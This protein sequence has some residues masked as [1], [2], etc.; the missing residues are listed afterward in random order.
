MN[1]NI[2]IQNVWLVGG[3]TLVKDFITLRLADEIIL[4]I[5]S[6]TYYLGRQGTIFE[7]DWTRTSI[8][9]KRRERI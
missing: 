8:T 4:S 7:P 6:I 9:S 5:L 3:A 2:K 1:N